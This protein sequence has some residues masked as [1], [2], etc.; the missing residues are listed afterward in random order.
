MKVRRSFYTRTGE[1]IKSPVFKTNQ[2]IVVRLSV[3]SQADMAYNVDNVVLTDMLPAGF[4][5]ENPRIMEDREMPWIKNAFTP[6]YFDIRDDRI[7]YFVNVSP[8][9][10]N[11]YYLARCVTKGTFEQGQV[12]ADAMYNGNFRSYWGGG[13][14]VIN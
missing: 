3:S 1:L 14:V 5:I 2:L 12:S 11:Y 9:E 4:E 13:K 8:A 6:T 10:S 7:N